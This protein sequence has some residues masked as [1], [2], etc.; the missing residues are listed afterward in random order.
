MRV[1]EATF[2]AHRPFFVFRPFLAGLGPP[3]LGRKAI[4]EALEIRITL[5][6]SAQLLKFFTCDNH[7][8]TIETENFQTPLEGPN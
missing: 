1:I 5:A 8:T 7:F 4:L 3:R 2:E 6:V